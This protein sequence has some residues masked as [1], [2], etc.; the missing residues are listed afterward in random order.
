[1]SCTVVTMFFNLKNLVDSN[2]ETRPIEFYME[3]GKSTLSLKYPMIIFCDETVVEKLR[4]I[5][6]R[7]AGEDVSTKY[8][9]K[10]ISEYE[11]Y[12]LHWN[13]I[14]ENRKKS[15]GYKD[16]NDRNNVSYFIMGMFKPYAL[17]MSK[18]Y[19]YY[20]TTHFAWVDLGCSHIVR[21]FKTHAPKMLENPKPKVTVCYIHYR[22]NNEIYPYKNF[23]EYGGPCG[24][25]STAYTVESNYVERFYHST[26]NVFH[27]MLY[28]GYGH[29]DE[30]VMTYSFD[31]NPEIYNIYYGDYYSILSNYHE[32][33][34]D[35]T[36]IFKFFIM[37]ANYKGN[38]FLAKKAAVDLLNCIH[39]YNIEFQYKDELLEIINK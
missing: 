6:I 1:M 2:K 34:E 37:Q 4:A 38:I 19:N 5:R 30:T 8:I 39:K 7:E 26:M 16:T 20:N 25:A 10:N 21:D 23:I 35:H 36:S 12:T 9:I 33:L 29:T 3:N 15:L 22:S 18:I 32:P 14:N 17:M 24:I 27:D 11:L 13:T 28:N 31:R